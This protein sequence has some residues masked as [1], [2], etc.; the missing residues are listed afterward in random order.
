MTGLRKYPVFIGIL[1]AI[2]PGFGYLIL[3]KR[4][5]FGVLILAYSVLSYINAFAFPIPQGITA[6]VTLFD[7]FDVT[8][9]LLF[10]IAFGYDAYRLAKEERLAKNE[11]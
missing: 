11:K 7:V 2:L 4:I 5:G 1:N 3:Q 8:A 9:I 10:F 6:R